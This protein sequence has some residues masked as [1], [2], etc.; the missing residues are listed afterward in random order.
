MAT[1]TT[2]LIL[3]AA[4]AALL[5][6]GMLAGVVYKTRTQQRHVEG[7]T[8]RDQGEQNALQVRQHDAL[9]EDSAVNAPAAQVELDINTARACRLQRQAAVHRSEAA[10]SRDQLNEQRDHAA[11]S[12]S[13]KDMS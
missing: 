12:L 7:E 1:N 5:L 11:F 6:A 9:A 2:V 10:A 4:M 8:I 3:V 13:I